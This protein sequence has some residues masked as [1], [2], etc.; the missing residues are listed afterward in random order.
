MIGQLAV[1]LHHVEGVGDIAV[2]PPCPDP[3]CRG[4]EVSYPEWE[5]EV[6]P[7][8]SCH[9]A[10]VVG[11][12]V[13]H[14]ERCATCD[15]KGVTLDPDSVGRAFAAVLDKGRGS[16]VEHLR[17]VCGGSGWVRDQ[18]VRVLE[19][20]PISPWQGEGGDCPRDGSRHIVAEVDGSAFICGGNND[21]TFERVDLPGAVPGGTA[22]LTEPVEAVCE[23]CGEA[24]TFAASDGVWRGEDGTLGYHAALRLPVPVPAPSAP[25]TEEP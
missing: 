8:E 24:L 3:A 10:P 21:G 1:P 2:L 15:G 7:C 19:V 23:S 9:G 12:V 20:L 6:R 14:V 25:Y 13:A 5:G 4:G 18:Y 16:G 22:I 11:Q 17:C